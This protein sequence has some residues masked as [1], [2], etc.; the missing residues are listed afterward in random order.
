[1]LIFVIPVTSESGTLASMLTLSSSQPQV[2]GLPPVASCQSPWSVLQTFEEATESTHQQ[3]SS[4]SILSS[5]QTTFVGSQSSSL[6]RGD[7]G[8][9]MLDHKD[10]VVS[11]SSDAAE[12]LAVSEHTEEV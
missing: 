3:T 10:M 1:M 2:A 4:A 7:A 5:V 11:L 12:L 6:S 9:A 8:L